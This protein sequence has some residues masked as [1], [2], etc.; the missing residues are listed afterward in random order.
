MRS[1]IEW[2]AERM[3]RRLK[4]HDAQKGY[5]GWRGYSLVWLCSRVCAESESL[6]KLVQ[7]LENTNR[8]LERRRLYLRI[9]KEAVDIAN[10][11]MMVADNSRS[12]RRLEKGALEE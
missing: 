4:E 9:I 12:F 2:F 5:D 1:V 11:S 8:L 6:I 3:E 7:E 10:V